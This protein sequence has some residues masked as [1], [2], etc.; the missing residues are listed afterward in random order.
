[1]AFAMFGPS[2]T[3]LRVGLGLG[4]GIS[5]ATLHALSPLHAAPIQCQYSA[6]YYRPET[7]A[8]SETG[9]AVPPNDPLLSKQGRTRVGAQPR[10]GFITADNMRQVSLGSVTGL[11][12]GLGLRALSKVLVVV[13]GVGVV[14]VEVCDSYPE[15]YILWSDGT[16]AY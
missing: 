11:I 4:I 15:D 7:Q 8:N 6:P 5:A 14:L 9:W 1:M 2:S 16:N 12:A 13:L 3:I 10:G